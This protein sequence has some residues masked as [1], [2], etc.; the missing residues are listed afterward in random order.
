MRQ[1]RAAGQTVLIATTNR[2]SN[3]H[4][5]KLLTVARADENSG[6]SS[7][8]KLVVASRDVPAGREVLMP[9][10]YGGADYYQIVADN[11]RTLR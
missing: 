11:Y 2:C 1:L 5:Q 8:L 7:P 9:A 10:G 3:R 6:K 4:A